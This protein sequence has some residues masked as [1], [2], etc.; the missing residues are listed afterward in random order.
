M[1]LTLLLHMVD[2]LQNSMENSQHL[3]FV[4]AWFGNSPVDLKV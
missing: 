2:L 3:P 4:S 1:H